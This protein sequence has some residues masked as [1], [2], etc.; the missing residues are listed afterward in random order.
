MEN[1]RN[2][3]QTKFLSTEPEA[4]TCT[5]KRTFLNFQIIQDSLVSVNF[6]Q[7]SFFWNKP[8]PVGAAVLDLS[9]IV[10]YKFN[11]NEMK[12]KFGDSLKVV[13]KDTDSL[14]YRRETDD[15]YSDMESFKHLLDLS[16]YPQ[17]HKLFDSTNK[18]VPLTMK[19]E[20]NGQIMLE[21]T[22]LRSKLYSIKF[23]S[24]I[25]QSAKGVQKCVKKS[26]HHDLLND[27]LYSRGNIRK[28]VT[29]IQSQEHQLLVTQ[30]SKIVM[31]AFDDKRFTLEDGIQSF[32]YGHYSLEQTSTFCHVLFGSTDF[33]FEHYR[34][35][36]FNIV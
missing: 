29:Q 15:L 23:E 1:L 7:S 4:K 35:L 30:I 31:G 18:K 16:D 20:L 27:V 17:N 5:L 33:S 36:S 19:D 11:Y 9:K 28:N 13:Y 14:L 10:L 25:K 26:L 32:T 21:A 22:C 34:L 6:T 3:R 24:G 12:P 8:T 2:R